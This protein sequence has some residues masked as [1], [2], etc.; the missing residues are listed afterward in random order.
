MR[1]HLTGLQ[2]S[3]YW[4]QYDNNV[5]SWVFRSDVKNRVEWAM[6]ILRILRYNT[7]LSNCDWKL[8]KCYMCLNVWEI[9]HTSSIK[10][11]FFYYSKFLPIP[12]YFMY[13]FPRFQSRA[14]HAEA[15]LS[16]SITDIKYPKFN[17]STWNS[18][19][20]NL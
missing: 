11:V 19:K 13:S 10:S 7:K 6:S 2:G 17:S 5:F 18:Y 8:W 3:I 1:T 20:V 16:I 4:D 14:A 12:M 9:M 15:S